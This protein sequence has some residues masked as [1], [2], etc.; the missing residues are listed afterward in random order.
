MA[1]EAAA[2]IISND[3][4]VSGTTYSQSSTTV[5]LNPGES[6]QIE[7]ESDPPS[8]PTDDLVVGVFPTIDGGTTFSN[9]AAIEFTI[10]NGTDPLYKNFVVTGW[11]GFKL[12]YKLTGSTDSFTVRARSRKDGISV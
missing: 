8:S 10:D 6:C 4:S 5:Y 7:I 1:W 2:T 3:V 11:H 9:T 12:M